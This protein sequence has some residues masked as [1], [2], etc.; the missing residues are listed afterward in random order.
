MTKLF[1]LIAIISITGA[2]IGRSVYRAM[3]RR[4]AYVL[5]L[6][7]FAAFYVAIFYW[8]KGSNCDFPATVFVPTIGALAGSSGIAAGIS[9]ANPEKYDYSAIGLGIRAF[10][11]SILPALMFVMTLWPCG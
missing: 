5:L 6:I 8:Y 7:A 10:L 9:W 2:L 1:I 11:A 3:G 4:A